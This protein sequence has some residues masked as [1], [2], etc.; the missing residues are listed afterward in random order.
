MASS[1]V[2]REEAAACQETVLGLHPLAVPCGVAREAARRFLR[3]RSE[4]A[5]DAR[6]A[7]SR[8]HR[9]PGRRPCLW[10]AVPAAGRR[11]RPSM[12]G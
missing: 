6:P 9:V 5:V 3:V 8:R 1:A 7:C 12:A 10:V 2:A 4:E 11:K